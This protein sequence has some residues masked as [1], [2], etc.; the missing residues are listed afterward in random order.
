[1]PCP[2]GQLLLQQGPLFMAT[3]KVAFPCN[4]GHGSEGLPP[5]PTYIHPR[6]APHLMAPNDGS[7]FLEQWEPQP[8]PH[9]MHRGPQLDVDL[10][11]LVGLFRTPSSRAC[12]AGNP[13]CPIHGILHEFCR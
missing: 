3:D 6:A 1:M 10:A 7:Q 11:L 12:S 8:N 13:P 2:H 4:V 9:K 5:I